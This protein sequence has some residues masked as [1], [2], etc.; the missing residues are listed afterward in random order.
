VNRER[1]IQRKQ[2]A[3]SPVARSIRWIPFGHFGS[4]SASSLF[5]HTMKFSVTHLC[6]FAFVT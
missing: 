6:P 1:P 3:R 4:A 5:V 2:T